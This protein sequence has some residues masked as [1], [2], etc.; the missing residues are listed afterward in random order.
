MRMFELFEFKLV[1][2]ENCLAIKKIVILIDQIVIDNGKLIKTVLNSKE[3]FVL[4]EI[5]VIHV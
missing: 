1:A 3:K 4:F 2:A 5:D